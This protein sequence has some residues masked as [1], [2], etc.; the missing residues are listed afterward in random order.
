MDYM[1]S[2]TLT[3]DDFTEMEQRKNRLKLPAI[4]CSQLGTTDDPYVRDD[5]RKTRLHRAETCKVT[6]LMK[7]FL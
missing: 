3:T 4:A 2:R 7:L 5:Y 1:Y 6:K